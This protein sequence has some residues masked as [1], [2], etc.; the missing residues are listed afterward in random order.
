MMALVL[1][2]ACV[3]DRQQSYVCLLASLA[4]A[5]EPGL[6]HRNHASW[7]V[8]KAHASL[9]ITEGKLYIFSGKPSNQKKS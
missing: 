6:H 9:A 4:A 5:L 3:S 7:R 2:W 8:G 1:K